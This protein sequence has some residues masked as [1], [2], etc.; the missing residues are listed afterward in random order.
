MPTAPVAARTTEPQPHRVSS[1]IRSIIPKWQVSGVTVNRLALIFILTLLWN[2]ITAADG[3]VSTQFQYDIALAI[4]LIAYPTIVVIIAISLRTPPPGW[5]MH[6]KTKRLV[7]LMPALV[8]AIAIAMLAQVPALTSP[9]APVGND[10]T[11]S[12]ICASR[13]V[14]HGHDPY[15]ESDI[16]CLESLHAPVALGTVL[17]R[18][19][20]VHQL[21]PPT[22]AQVNRV[23]AQSAPNHYRNPAFA[24]FG[25]LPMSFV[26]MLPAALGNNQAWVTYTLIAGILLL[27]FAGLAAGELWPAMVLALLVQVGDG[28]L[29]VSALTAD[30]E[31]FAYGLLVLA[32]C[33][34]DRPKI[35]GVLMGVAMASHPLAWVVWFGCAIFTKNKP[36]FR[37]R[38][39]YSLGTAAVLIVPWLIV[40][41]HALTAIVTLVLQPTYP[42]G[43]GIITL[44]GVAPP[45]ILRHVLL[46][47]IVGGFAGLCVFA[48]RRQSWLALLPVV[49]LSFM[50]LGW[51]S[52]IS[53]LA[54]LF[55]LAAAMA[56]GLYRYNARESRDSNEMPT[57]ANTDG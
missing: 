38:M 12:I 20:F 39:L 13:N 35:S 8:V 21:R 34:V 33:W 30:G 44:F 23:V 16:A 50:W 17:Q 9:K 48:W 5:L 18:G 56:I 41:P 49:G 53:Y 52:N 42:A 25:Y 40:E 27:L 10:I 31:F 6:L 19:A 55:P 57:P 51:R 2:L 43:P 26:E 15:L 54:E 36:H 24:T 1:Y 11:S 7:Q 4:S 45:A 32:L 14:L 37:Q 3:V 46:A 22:K 47:V 28:G 29:F